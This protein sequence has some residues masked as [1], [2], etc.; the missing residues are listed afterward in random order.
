MSP[1][2]AFQEYSREEIGVIW[3]QI[4]KE[5]D[6]LITHMMPFGYCDLDWVSYKRYGCKKLREKIDN[7]LKKLKYHL[8]GHWHAA[9]GAQFDEVDKNRNT[10]FINAS[11]V[12]SFFCQVQAPVVFDYKLDL[13]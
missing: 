2:K 11:S 6:V 5:T 7:D 12:T 9:Y 13:C 4:P 10:V 8:F 1:N 3:D